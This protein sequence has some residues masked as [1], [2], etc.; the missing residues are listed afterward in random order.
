[1]TGS[2]GLNL[3]ATGGLSSALGVGANEL[4]LEPGT[5]AGQLKQ[6]NGSAWVN[7]QSKVETLSGSVDVY[8]G[9][10]ENVLIGL[11]RSSLCFFTASW[12]NGT[13]DGEGT[14]SWWVI[15][16]YDSSYSRT[17]EI[18]DITQTTCSDSQTSKLVLVTTGASMQVRLEATNVF[19]SAPHSE[20]TWWVT[21]M[22]GH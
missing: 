5:G 11:N 13:G 1:M 22:G 18:H 7:V 8:F 15:V 21:Q 20:M 12:G 14:R 6:W 4:G 9:T 19:S 3:N 10:T 2:A 17:P 16:P